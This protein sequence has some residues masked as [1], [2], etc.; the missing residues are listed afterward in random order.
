MKFE[1]YKLIRDQA[2][3]AC[4]AEGAPLPDPRQMHPVLLA[5]VGDIVFSLYVR[6]RLLATSGQVRVIHDLGAKMVSAVMQARAMDALEAI[7][8]E[9][10]A[11]VVRRGRN[12]KSTVPKSATVREYRQGTAF[13]ALVGWLFLLDRQERLVEIL[14]DSFGIIR[15]EIS[16]RRT[17]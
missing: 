4:F 5:Y 6:L 3:A 7:L 15:K 14:D 1:H 2:L 17:L 16:D 13:E 10:E 11:A 9:E 8:S 12:T